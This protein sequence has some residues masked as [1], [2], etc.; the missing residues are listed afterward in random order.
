[1]SRMSA[2][3]SDGHQAPVTRRAKR[4]LRS[5]ED[6]RNRRRRH[7][8]LGLS[9]ALCVLLVNSIVGDNGY[10]AAVRYRAEEAALLA[11]VAK[12]RED[13][14]W[15]QE[16]RKRLTEDP[17][18]L[19]EEARASLGLIKPGETLLIVRP[20]VPPASVPPAR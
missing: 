5:A 14:K 3:S 4:R 13:N 20:A 19:D 1:M 8:T 7:I 17:A 15:L 6:T 11:A 10:L 16:Q 12:L 18:A 2:E 9:V